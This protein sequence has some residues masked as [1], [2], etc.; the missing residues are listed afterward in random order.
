MSLDDK[1]FFLDG[2]LNAAEQNVLTNLM[3]L[4][5]SVLIMSDTAATY[6]QKKKR[7]FKKMCALST[8]AENVKVTKTDDGFLVSYKMDEKSYV[9]KFK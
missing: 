5:T 4:F 1:E 2:R 3:G 6:D 7:R 9:V 8:D